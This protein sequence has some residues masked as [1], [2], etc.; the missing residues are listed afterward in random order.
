MSKNELPDWDT[1]RPPLV[2]M[3]PERYVWP[4]VTAGTYATLTNVDVGGGETVVLEGYDAD[5]NHVTE[6]LVMG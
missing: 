2:F 6:T 3:E 1:D 4:P 5:G